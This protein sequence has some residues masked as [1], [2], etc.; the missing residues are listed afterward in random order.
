MF[1]VSYYITALK[2]CA[3]DTAMSDEEFVRNLLYPYIST[4]NIKDKEKNPLDLNKSRVSRLLSQKDDVP[5]AIRNSLVIYGVFEDTKEPF[6]NFIEDYLDPHQLPSL[7]REIH[8]VIMNTPSI[9]TAAKNAITELTNSPHEFLH[10]TF[11]EA[12]KQNNKIE[13]KSDDYLWQCGTNTLQL[14]CGD[15]FKFGFDN[16]KK[17]QNII[18]I[19]INTSFDTHISWKAEGTDDPIVAPTTL[20]GQWINR[21]IKA[22][23]TID[24][25]NS[26]INENLSKQKLSY[27]YD[28]IGRRH[29]D[30][31]SIAVITSNN[32]IYYLLA[33]SAF[34]EQNIAHSSA[35]QIRKAVHSLMIFYNHYGM[36][37]PMYLP[38]LGTGR[39]RAALDYQASFDLICNEITREPQLIQGKIT[40]VASKEAMATIHMEVD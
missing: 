2:Q 3:N 21:W 9:T 35:I 19:P 28:L 11:F 1:T 40:I 17:Q 31:G 7:V 14:L 38:L 34:D 13:T 8:D 25:L 29:Y 20:H 4:A 37:Y 26:Q 32:S 16:R 30:I 10:Y 24:E 12:L 39:S 23:N 22:G 33:I 15:I 36:G 27:T 6:S 18:V 5:T